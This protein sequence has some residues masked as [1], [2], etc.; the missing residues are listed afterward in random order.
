MKIIHYNNEVNLN[1]CPYPEIPIQEH[2]V[3]IHTQHSYMLPSNL[4]KVTNEQTKAL[5]STI[6]VCRTRYVWKYFEQEQNTSHTGSDLIFMYSYKIIRFEAHLSIKSNISSS[7]VN[8]KTRKQQKFRAIKQCHVDRR[9]KS[10]ITTVQKR[11]CGKKCVCPP[12]NH[13]SQMT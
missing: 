6:P 1:S 13:L 5:D 11:K 8:N 4:H 9:S 7:P 12:E 3:C 10:H 2:I